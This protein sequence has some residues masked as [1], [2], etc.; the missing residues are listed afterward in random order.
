MNTPV[1][2]LV[3]FSLLSPLC[4][5]PVSLW[6]VSLYTN[7]QCKNGEVQITIRLGIL[8][9]VTVWEHWGNYLYFVCMQWAWCWCLYCSWS[10]IKILYSNLG[11]LEFSHSCSAKGS[12][13]F[14]MV[15]KI[16]LFSIS[17]NWMLLNTLDIN[18]NRKVLQIRIMWESVWC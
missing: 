9:F 2:R 12:N 1:C 18:K 11:K 13:L 15:W 3:V 5:K 7:T 6:W 4:T 8:D 10:D 16:F 14:W 17:L